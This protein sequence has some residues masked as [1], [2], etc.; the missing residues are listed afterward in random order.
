VLTVPK[1]PRKKAIRQNQILESVIKRFS[2]TK[3]LATF[4]APDKT[5][6]SKA[7]NK[8]ISEILSLK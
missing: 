4:T 6:Y 5:H 2:E 7:R 1:S 8:S 3:K